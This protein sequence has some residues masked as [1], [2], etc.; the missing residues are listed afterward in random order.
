MAGVVGVGGNG[1][2]HWIKPQPKFVGYYPKCV[3]A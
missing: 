1:M 2:H 3:I